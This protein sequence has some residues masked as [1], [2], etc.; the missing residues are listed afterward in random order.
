MMTHATF[1]RVIAVSFLEKLAV[2]QEHF[3]PMNESIEEETASHSKAV[4]SSALSL[5]EYIATV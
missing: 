5:V 1:L 4:S 2:T 3:L